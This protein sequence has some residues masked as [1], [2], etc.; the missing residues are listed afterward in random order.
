MYFHVALL[1]VAVEIS[2]LVHIPIEVMRKLPRY[3]TLSVHLKP[4]RIAYLEGSRDHVS[5]DHSFPC[6]PDLDTLCDALSSWCFCLPSILQLEQF[7]KSSKISGDLH[8]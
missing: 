6:H 2:S 3:V 4:G 5:A 7:P 1:E 8:R